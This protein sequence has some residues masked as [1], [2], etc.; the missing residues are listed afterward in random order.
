MMQDDWL[1]KRQKVLF[2]SPFVA[3]SL[4]ACYWSSLRMRIS[5]DLNLLYVLS[6]K[7]SNLLTSILLSDATFCSLILVWYVARRDMV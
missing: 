1:V 4:F 5:Y 2:F 3:T 6:S 7:F